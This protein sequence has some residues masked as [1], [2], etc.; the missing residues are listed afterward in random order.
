MDLRKSKYILPNLFT[1]AS[2][3]F[4]LFAIASVM[5]GAGSTGVRR[6]AIAILVALIADGL[7]GRVAR[8]TRSET[9]FGVQLDSLADVISFGVAPGILGYSFALSHMEVSWVGLLIA[10]I[11][12]ACGAMR[13]A[14]FNVMTERRSKPTP[15]FTGLPIPA[16]AG[17]VATL[18]WGMSD[19]GVSE[20]SRI[21]PFMVTMIAMGL[22]MVS[23]VRYR[24][25]KQVNAGLGTRIALML[26]ASSLIIAMI[27]IKASYTLLAFGAVYIFLGPTEWLIRLLRR[28]LRVQMKDE[29]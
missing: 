10:F 28:Q 12:V 8:M 25:F 11:Y 2:V 6:A 26:L 9:K 4:G 13:L 24:N 5:E 18:A 22:L 29:E 27:K 1:L 14:R 19:L 20:R 17:I 15:W 21:I 3:F 23:N 7:D 16:A